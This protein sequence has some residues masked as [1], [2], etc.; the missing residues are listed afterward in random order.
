MYLI[1]IWKL[2]K[3]NFISNAVTVIG[4]NEQPVTSLGSIYKSFYDKF[5]KSLDEQTLREIKNNGIW[6]G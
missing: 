1:N 5:E 4:R 2:N 3:V 6:V